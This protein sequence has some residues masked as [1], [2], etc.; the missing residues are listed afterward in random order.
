MTPVQRVLFATCF[1]ECALAWKG[2]EVAGFWLPDD[3]RAEAH[4][5]SAVAEAEVPGWVAALIARVRRHLDRDFQDFSGLPYDWARVSDFQKAVYLKTVAI[6]AGS[7]LSYGEVARSIGVGNEG[8]RAVGVA[9][10]SNPW[11]LLIP[12]HRVVASNGKMTG[13]SSPGGIRTK[14]RL[15]ALEGAELLS[16]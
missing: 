2:E 10:G 7:T 5:S 3:R 4:R 14:T 12:C 1:G 9:L 15:L 11:P 13:F 6:P 16:E 8:S